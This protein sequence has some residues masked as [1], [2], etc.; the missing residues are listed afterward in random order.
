MV[1]IPKIFW[2]WVPIFWLLGQIALEV[3]LPAETI[4]KIHAE[5]SIHEIL[6]F[7]MVLAACIIAIYTLVKLHNKEL[8]RVGWL[9]LMAICCFYVAIEEISW[10]Q[11]FFNWATPD[12]WQNINNQQETNLHNTSRW[13]NQIPRYGLMAGIAVGGFLIP[14]VKWAKPNLLPQKFNDVYPSAYF[15][16]SALCL[17]IVALGHKLSKTFL[18]MKLFERASEVEEI[19]IY[20]FVLLYAIMIKNNFLKRHG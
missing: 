7:L 8:W 13:L 19:F 3:F 4:L 9:S 12:Y 10:G 2:L 16:I 15:T 20:F 18:D 14:F 11:S 1:G 17:L 5:G 6:Q